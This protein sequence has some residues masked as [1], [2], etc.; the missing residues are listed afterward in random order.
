MIVI[1]SGSEG[2][3]I[4]SYRW[5]AE[6]RKW[7]E[8]F[9]FAQHDRWKKSRQNPIGDGM[10]RRGCG[11]PGRAA[12]VNGVE[13]RFAGRG[14]RQRHFAAGFSEGGDRVT[15]RFPHRDREHEWRFADGFASVH[16]VRLGRVGK[17]RDVENIRRVANRR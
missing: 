14:R 7:S 17:K 4:I 8:M 15:N 2:S 13:N 1:L 3:L 16:N 10:L 9:R 11:I 12:A 6:S 5:S